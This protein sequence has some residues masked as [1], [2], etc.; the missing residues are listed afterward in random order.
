[1]QIPLKYIA[2]GTNSK[3]EEIFYPK[4]AATVPENFTP[5]GLH[6]KVLTPLFY[7]S[8]V[9]YAHITEYIYSEELLHDD[10]QRTFWTSDP[11][12]LL[13]LLG[14]KQISDA[15]PTHLR[16]SSWMSSLQW[17]TLRYLRRSPRSSS[18]KEVLQRSEPLKGSVYSDIRAFRLSALDRF[19]VS[20]CKDSQAEEYRIAVSTLLLSDYI[21]FGVPELI[22]AL[23]LCIRLLLCYTFV[24]TMVQWVHTLFSRCIFMTASSILLSCNA[25]HI[26]WLFKSIL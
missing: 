23:D 2:S 9:R 24:D 21:A 16:Y 17:A 7:S 4:T 15:N 14:E 10:K 1:M 26:W 18:T 12:A 25:V 5:D 3:R 19:V 13:Q 6:F 20:N 11:Q 22:D 8:V